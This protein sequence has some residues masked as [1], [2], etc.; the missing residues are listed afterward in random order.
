M[1]AEE[2][3]PEL[4]SNPPSRYPLTLLFSANLAEWIVVRRST[5]KRLELAIFVIRKFEPIFPGAGVY[6]SSEFFALAGALFHYWGSAAH[7]T[8]MCKG[9]SPYITEAE[10]FDSPSLTA[11]LVAAIYTF[12]KFCREVMFPTFVRPAIQDT[13]LAPTNQ[14]RIRC[15]KN[16][17]RVFAKL[18]SRGT[19][20]MG[21][22]QSAALVRS[23]LVSQTHGS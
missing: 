1:T 11:C 17:F 16:A 5:S 13:F 22:L 2:F 21:E 14:Q 12:M 9:I 20:R 8:D 23:A 18:R 7:C 3:Q 6:G 15:G 19:A 4:S 10:L